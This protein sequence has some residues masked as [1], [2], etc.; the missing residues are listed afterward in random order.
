MTRSNKSKKIGWPERI[1]RSRIIRGIFRLHI[2]V[3][4][5]RTWSGDVQVPH[6]TTVHLFDYLL[7]RRTGTEEPF[8]EWVRKRELLHS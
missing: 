6:G 8:M 3:S 1:L 5:I 4:F 7:Y 2:G